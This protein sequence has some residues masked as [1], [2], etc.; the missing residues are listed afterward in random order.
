MGKKG[1]TLIELL[2]TIVVLAI[3]SIITVPIISGVIEN[4]RVEAIRNSIYGMFDAADLFYA[5]NTTVPFEDDKI[6]FTC[7]GSGCKTENNAKLNFKGIIPK[8]GNIYLYSNSK[9]EASYIRIDKYCALGDRET[10]DIQL[11]CT[12][13]DI[14]KPEFTLAQGGISSNSI[15][16]G[17]SARDLE[18]GISKI[19]YEVDG[20]KYVDT[21]KDTYNLDI[22]KSFIE[23][24]SDK[25]YL[26]K[27]AITNGNGLTET[28][29]INITT[30]AFT[31]AISLSSTK[32][33]GKAS[34]SEVWAINATG[35]I[36]GYY[37]KSTSAATSSVN[38]IKSCGTNTDPENCENITSSK[39]MQANTWYYTIDK[40]NITYTTTSTLSATLYAKVT[41]GKNNTNAATGLTNLEVG[42]IYDDTTGNL[43]ATWK[44]LEDT[45]NLN[46]EKDYT[47][48]N[49][50]TDNGTSG[51]AMYYVLNTNYSSYSSVK[52]IMPDGVTKIGNYAFNF[53]SS[54]TS[55][56]IPNS[57]T[58]IGS[59]AFPYTGLTSITIPSSVTSIGSVAFA[60][61]SKL[62]SINVNSGN[63]K[64]ISID[65]I[66]F[67]KNKTTLIRYPEAKTGTTYTIPNSVT[68]IRSFAF[69]GC[70]KLT[71]ITIPNSVTSIG[72]SAFYG[73]SALTSITIPNS[74]TS[75]GDLAFNNCSKLTSIT[76][77]NSVTS[78]GDLAFKA[79]SKLTSINVNSGNT[80]YTSI[81][82]ILFDKNKTALISYPEGKTGTT[83]TIPSSV[84]N[85]IGSAFSNTGLTSITIPS[86][87][88]S[89]GISAF[90]N[91]GLTSITIPS[92]VTSI[93]IYAFS[94][95]K[96]L[97]KVTFSNTSGWWVTTSYSATSGTAV[98]VTN[99][100]TN[101]TNLTT[102]YKTYYWKRG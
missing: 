12:K 92:S 11:D 39:N 31:S 72:S 61:C 42:G 67:D 68:S 77:P 47:S 23:L 86:S 53:C 21:Y 1:F 33:I 10:L 74:V 60:A 51:N 5:Q 93:G 13:L 78:I 57:V 73:C 22:T 66:L 9:T 75:I 2:A 18:S 95:C 45:Y 41:D 71:S 101:A 28:K 97:T 29:T 26:I 36:E 65:G 70:S 6:I 100:A 81:D 62:T 69:N 59:S 44:Y 17:V 85:I 3:V 87:V 34:S 27:V 20:K 80:K 32:S 88:T 15:I 79:C 89:I 55:I 99:T 94:Y 91:T 30:E 90:A 96:N 50:K 25:S 19:E 56:V 43:I 52:V 4:V 64:Y 49:S 38:L 63:S 84:T 35:D 16:L 46:I 98:T 8:S 24:N 102:T 54:L 76:I 82:G 58:S 83:Y 40:P 14:T 7:D 37:V 48:S